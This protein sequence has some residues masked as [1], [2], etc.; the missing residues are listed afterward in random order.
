MCSKMTL[1][2]EFSV[3]DLL[4]FFINGHLSDVCY[5]HSCFNV[6]PFITALFSEEYKIP[7]KSLTHVKDADFNY[8]GNQL[9]TYREFLTKC[10]SPILNSFSIT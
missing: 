9:K 5:G 1:K 10:D 6:G 3:R 2:Q 4:D 8:R 7:T